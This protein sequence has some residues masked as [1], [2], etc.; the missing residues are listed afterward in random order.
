MEFL[1]TNCHLIVYESC[2]VLP[3]G[4]V[5]GYFNCILYLEPLLDSIASETVAVAMES[6]KGLRQSNCMRN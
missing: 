2:T 4:I 6:N 3:E 5:H 1:G